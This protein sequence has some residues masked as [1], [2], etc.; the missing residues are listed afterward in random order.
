[1]PTMS[2]TAKLP[3]EYTRDY[4]NLDQLINDV[5][6]NE[7]IKQR[8]Y[9][10]KEPIEPLRSHLEEFILSYILRGCVGKANFYTAKFEFLRKEE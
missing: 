2:I 6:N 3:E 4:D 1:M 8:Y 7:G 5:C 9:N 10:T